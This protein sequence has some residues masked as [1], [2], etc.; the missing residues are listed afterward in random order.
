MMLLGIADD[1]L[2]GALDYVKGKAKA[3][4]EEA[5]PDIQSQVKTTVEP[6]VVGALLL[7]AV[8][9]TFGLAS[10]MRTRRAK[11][12]AAGQLSGRRRR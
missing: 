3:G 4:A 6:Y 5:I 8:G 2:G 11:R 7:G 10:Y 9:A 12:A 1:L